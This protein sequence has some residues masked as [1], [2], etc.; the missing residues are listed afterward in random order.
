MFASCVAVVRYYIDDEPNASLVFTPAM[1]AA[2]SVGREGAVYYATN[3]TDP[4]RGECAN[5][6][7]HVKGP[8]LCGQDLLDGW[9]W[10]A[11]LFGKGGASG[12]WLHHFPV[13]FARSL[14][15][16][17]QLACGN[18]TACA[19]IPPSLRRADI[20]PDAKV[21]GGIMIRGLTGSDDEVRPTLAA[22]APPVKLPPIRSGRMRL[23]LTRRLSTPVPYGSVVPLLDHA[24]G[25]SSEAGLV[26]AVAVGFDGWNDAAAGERGT[27]SIEGCWWALDNPDATLRTGT[28]GDERAALLLGTGV[29]DLFG[30]AFGMSWTAAGSLHRDGNA[31]LVHVRGGVTPRGPFPGE[32]PRRAFSAYRLFLA[33]P[34][35]WR[36]GRVGLYWRNGGAKCSLPTMAERGEAAMRWAPDADDYAEGTAPAPGASSVESYVWW[37]SFEGDV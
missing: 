32:R 29:E 7:A 17:V 2:S 16:T 9:P 3:A 26:L 37:L 35:P 33:D 8:V 4:A 24:S 5:K 19:D 12:S 23:H 13:P 30:D 14:R 28:S 36:G 34:L 11:P 22:L 25:R 20:G 10:A 21:I 18:A 6:P 31:G 1:A 27:L 15:A